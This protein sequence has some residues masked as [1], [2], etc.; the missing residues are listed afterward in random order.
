M[1]HGSEIKG[2]ETVLSPCIVLLTA[3]RTTLARLVR[4]RQIR[5]VYQII[6]ATRRVAVTDQL[7]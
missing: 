5:C 3:G 2:D 7:D 4:T 6:V 1:V